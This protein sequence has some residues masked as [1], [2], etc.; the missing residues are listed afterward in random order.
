MITYRAINTK[1]GKFYIGSTTDFERRKGSHLR[2][3]NNYPFQ[4][5]LQ[6]DPEAF[7]WEVAED[8]SD[9]PLLEQ[10]LL[11]MWFGT[12]QCYNLNPTADRPPNLSGHRFSEATLN[13]RSQSR[14]GKPLPSLQGK[15]LSK[16]HRSKISFNNLGK[17]GLRGEANG[18]SKLTDEQRREIRE[19]YIP[20]K[21]GEG[22]SSSL[23]KEYGVSKQQIIRVVKGKT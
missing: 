16:E 2:C 19:R 9:E 7:V 10:A 14:R 12:E 5:A 15:P 3:K 11:D 22:S 21:R 17:E 13:K 20:G 1:N 18:N 23:A 6:K 8:D 4:K